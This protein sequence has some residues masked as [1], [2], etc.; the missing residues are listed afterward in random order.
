MKKNKYN[1]TQIADAKA[2]IDG[3]NMQSFPVNI[4][5]D[6]NAVVSKIESGIPYTIIAKNQVQISDGEKFIDIL[7]S[8]LH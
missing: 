4:F 6:K 1:F 3:M 7:K 2:F 8:F 5:L